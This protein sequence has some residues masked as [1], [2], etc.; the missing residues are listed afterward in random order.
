VLGAVTGAS[1]DVIE[2]GH[3]GGT[4]VVLMGVG[5]GIGANMEEIGLGD[6]DIG[7]W[8]VLTGL[9]LGANCRGGAAVTCGDLT[10]DEGLVNMAGMGLEHGIGRIGLGPAAN[11]AGIGL[12]HSGICGGLA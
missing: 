3:D 5:G 1:I 11:I 2:L 7:T 9:G 10:V 6:G 8:G 4:S 12:A